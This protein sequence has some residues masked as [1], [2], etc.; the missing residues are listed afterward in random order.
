MGEEFSVECE[1][2]WSKE[3]I[4]S[5]DVNWTGLKHDA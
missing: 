2:G 1:K 4:Y 3:D 5:A